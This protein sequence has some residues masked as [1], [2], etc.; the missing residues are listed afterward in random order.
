[1]KTF[2]LILTTFTL[3]I[4]FLHAQAIPAPGV[5]P[6]VSAVVQAALPP[7]YAAYGSLI[8]VVGMIL[9]RAFTAIR[10]NGGLVGIYNAIVHGTTPGAKL[11]LLSGLCL[12]TVPSCTT[13]QKLGLALSTPKAKQI[14]IGLAQIGLV[15]AVIGGVVSPGDALTIARGVAIVTSADTGSTKTVKL[16]KLGLDTAVDKGIVKPGDVV[17][18]KEVT[19]TITPAAAPA[20]VPVIEM[21]SGK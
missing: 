9:G 20:P 7:Q 1:M 13:M 19:A 12:L 18:I 17:T 5:D 10:S 2:F 11:L 8:L 21:T 16:A 15:G 6:D 14:E 3:A 4:T